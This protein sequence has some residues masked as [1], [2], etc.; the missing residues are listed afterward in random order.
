MK[1]A[2]NRRSKRPR[3]Q[4]R[5]LSG[6]GASAYGVGG[7]HLTAKAGKIFGKTIKMPRG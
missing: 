3:V 1:A 7:P 6:T 2:K 5:K 4:T